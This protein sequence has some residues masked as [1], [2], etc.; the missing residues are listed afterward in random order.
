MFTGKVLLLFCEKFHPLH[1]IFFPEVFPNAFAPQDMT[2]EP[3]VSTSTVNLKIQILRP[4]AAI[5]NVRIA[6][7]FIS[8][9]K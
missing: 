8:L 7:I 4:T 3:A 5:L 9:I 6:Y 2:P 1:L